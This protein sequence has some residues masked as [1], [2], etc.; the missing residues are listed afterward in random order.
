MSDALQ[1]LFRQAVAS[2]KGQNRAVPVVMDPDR[3]IDSELQR[4]R[5][6]CLMFAFDFERSFLLRL[7]PLLLVSPPPRLGGAL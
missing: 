2:D 7:A 5:L 4:N 6:F 3:C 1:L